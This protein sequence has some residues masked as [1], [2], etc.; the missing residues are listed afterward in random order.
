M[1]IEYLT[2]NTYNGNC[3]W[4]CDYKTAEKFL[5]SHHETF[6][7]IYLWDAGEDKAEVFIDVV[8]G[9][10][11]Y[12]YSSGDADKNGYAKCLTLYYLVKG[13]ILR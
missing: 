8:I 5:C 10:N 11:S 13:S 1:S 12:Q 3:R 9:N 2:N 4:V 6:C 7:S